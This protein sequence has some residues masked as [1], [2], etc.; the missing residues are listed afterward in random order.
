MVMYIFNLIVFFN[1]KISLF[2]YFFNPIVSFFLILMVSLFMNIFYF[3]CLFFSFLIRRCIGG[4]RVLVG[5]PEG[6]RTLG[7]PRRR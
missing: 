1:I 7:R 3:Y 6:K 5:K 4:Y 2:S